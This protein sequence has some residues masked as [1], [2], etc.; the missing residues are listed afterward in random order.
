MM[1]I[2]LRELKAHR[3]ALII[4]SVCMIL[5][6]YSGMYKYTAY[7]A[8]TAGAPSINDIVKAMPGTVRALFGFGSFD[9]STMAGYFAVL[10]VY[11][12]LALGIHAALLGAGII[13]KEE[14]D[15][16]TEYLMVK[17]VS[18][19]YII[20]SKLC[21]ALFNVVVLNLVL[22]LSS[23]AIVPA[24]N[25]GKD[26]SH[27]IL[28]I[29][30]SMFFL[31]LLF[32]T[33]GAGLAACMR[34]PKGA[35]S[36]VTGFILIAYFI[37]RVTDMNDRL[38]PLNILSPFKYFDLSKIVA[39]NGLNSGIVLITL[40]LIAVFTGSTYFFYSRRDLNV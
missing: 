13:S 21:A 11:I 19:G 33:L 5:G 22:L 27:E 30:L 35:G 12:Q 40:L 37:A 25:K 28:L 4:W 9:V 24:Y 31:Q 17:P 36:I 2:F 38:N 1:N 39:G 18:R 10:T 8:G 23:L 26:I 14:R 6:V 32:L 3:R 34:K 29:M 16:T 15:K 20:T 7:T